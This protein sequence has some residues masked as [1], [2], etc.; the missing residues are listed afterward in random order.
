MSNTTIAALIAAV[1]ASLVLAYSF[2]PSDDSGSGVVAASNAEVDDAEQVDEAT[3]VVR[4][5]F[6]VVRISREGTGVIAGRAEQDAF[7]EIHAGDEIIGRVR[8]NEAGEWVFLLESPLEEGAQEL[9]LVSHLEGADPV[10]SDDIVVL[11]IPEREQD[12]AAE[13]GV[14]AVLSPRYGGGVSRILQRPGSYMADYALQVSALDYDERGRV[15]FSGTAEEGAEIR[16]Y[17]DNE[18]VGDTTADASGRWSFSPDNHLFAGEHVL[19]LDQ[20]LDGDGV[21]IRVEQP[22]DTGNA[23]DIAMAESHVVVHPG[24]NLWHIA[25]RVYGSG[26]LFTQIFRA[27]N[28]SIKDPDLIYPGQKF[29]LPKA[30]AY[31]TAGT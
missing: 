17:L 10:E 22:F 29:L 25:R 27:N 24:N 31:D 18:Y 13:N 8:A 1:L 3:V 12:L 7:V 4:P 28:E 9:T 16:V 30:Q 15:T 21:E 14:I 19:R 6:D 20:I 5:S 2:W 23:L 11:A 26:V